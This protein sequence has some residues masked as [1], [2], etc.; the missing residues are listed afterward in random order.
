MFHSYFSYLALLNLYI[1]IVVQAI[2]STTHNAEEA[3]YKILFYENSLGMEFKLSGL[4]D[5][6]VIEDLVRVIMSCKY[7]CHW[8]WPLGALIQSYNCLVF[9]LW[10]LIQI[11]P[12]FCIKHKMLN[13]KVVL[14]F[15]TAMCISM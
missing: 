6:K 2:S 11:K 15:C 4:P 13:E 7:L 12:L 5:R 8:M 3:G 14:K 10:I 9:S 1:N